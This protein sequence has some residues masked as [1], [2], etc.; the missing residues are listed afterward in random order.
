MLKLNK[1]VVALFTLVAGYSI[2]S[3][4]WVSGT[5]VSYNVQMNVTS[6]GYYTAQSPAT[7]T[8]TKTGVN[9]GVGQVQLSGSTQIYYFLFDGS[10]NALQTLQFIKDA[11]AAGKVLNIN[12]YA[13][14]KLTYVQTNASG[15][16]L[17]G[18]YGLG[19]YNAPWIDA[20]GQ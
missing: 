13:N 19:H 8:G 9:V 16:N 7:I 3:A 17:H 11:K 18:S 5:V 15:Y 1:I 10:Q 12:F 14:E 6:Y 4:A 2:S 20:I